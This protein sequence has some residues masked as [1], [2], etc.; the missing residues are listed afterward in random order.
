MADLTVTAKSVRP[1]PSSIVREFTAGGSGN[2]GDIVY[3]DANGKVQ[4]TDADAAGTLVAIGVVVAVGSYGAT[5]FV[6]G[7]PVSVVI[8]GAVC[9]FSGL[10]PG[11][12]VYVSNTAGKL[13]D[14]AGTN[15]RVMGLAIGADTILVMNNFAA[16]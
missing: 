11:S 13:A 12:K 3:V 1:L 15:T 8:F 10:T 5:A 7:D 2:V 6:S 9:G 16:S 4:Q 14:A